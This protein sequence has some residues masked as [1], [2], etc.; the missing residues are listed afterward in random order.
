MTERLHFHFSLCCQ[1]LIPPAS[2]SSSW[3]S[4]LSIPPTAS[5]ILFSHHLMWGCYRFLG[6]HSET[7]SR[8]RTLRLL[9]FFAFPAPAPVIWQSKKRSEITK[10]KLVQLFS[11]SQHPVYS[12]NDTYRHLE[13]LYVDMFLLLA[14]LTH[15]TMSLKWSKT[16]FIFH[17]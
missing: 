3:S 1:C 17:H 12:L 7:C 10:L 14:C 2:Q 11:S 16:T 15:E 13:L 4:W 6:K 5:T 9:P 8:L